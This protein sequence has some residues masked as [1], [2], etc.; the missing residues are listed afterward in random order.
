M[1]PLGPGGPMGPKGPHAGHGAHGAPR[2]PWV[3]GG[4]CGQWG[5]KGPWGPWS[6][7][8]PWGPPRRPACGR[9]PG[10]K[11]PQIE[12]DIKLRRV[13]YAQPFGWWTNKL[14]NT[15]VGFPFCMRFAHRAAPRPRV[16][17]CLLILE[18]FAHTQGHGKRQPFSD[19][20][21]PQP[22]WRRV[23]IYIYI[24]IYTRRRRGWA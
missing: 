20:F 2:G 3:P 4:P 9:R 19:F 10:G 17:K 16:G 15:M 5:P 24:Y 1:G 14:S 23:Y 7:L 22:R 11:Y 8:G 18:Q 21:Y 6:P 13:E 12:N